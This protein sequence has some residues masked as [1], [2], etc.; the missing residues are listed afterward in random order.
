MGRFSL[1]R[2]VML[3]T[4]GTAHRMVLSGLLNFF[5]GPTANRLDRN[6][7]IHEEFVEECVLLFNHYFVNP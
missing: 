2:N 4:S 1:Q 3:T 7:A 6:N 5:L